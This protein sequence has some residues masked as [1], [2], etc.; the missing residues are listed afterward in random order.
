MLPELGL[1]PDALRAAI[2]HG[3]ATVGLTERIARLCY[4]LDAAHGRFGAPIVAGLKVL[5]VLT[6]AA[7][8][9][10]LWRRRLWR[11]RRAGA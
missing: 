9:A 3:S 7:M 6:L 1:Q 10:F 5:A 8:A 2:S 4:G 11:R